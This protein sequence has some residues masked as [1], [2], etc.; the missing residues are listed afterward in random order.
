MFDSIRMRYKLTSAYYPRI[1]LAG[2]VFCRPTS[3]VTQMLITILSAFWPGPELAVRKVVNATAQN[4]LG[5]RHGFVKCAIVRVQVMVDGGNSE[6]A[7]VAVNE[8]TQYFCWIR[9]YF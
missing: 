1:N 4:V 2:C 9:I 3:S 5:L 7:A 8:L 6:E